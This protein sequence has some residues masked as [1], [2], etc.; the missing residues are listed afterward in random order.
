MVAP[1]RSPRFPTTGR[2]RYQLFQPTRTRWASSSSR[3]SPASSASGT[4]PRVAR[5]WVYLADLDGS[6]LPDFVETA[7]RGAG[8]RWSYRLNTGAAGASR[9]ADEGAGPTIRRNGIGNFAVDTDGDGR[10]ELIAERRYRSG[11]GELG[12]E[13]GRWR[14][15]PAGEPG[16]RRRR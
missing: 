2:Y 4:P 15:D 10:T 6:G 7:V 5:R 3:R 11:L 1:T 16:G 13:R 8:E 14:G 9:F 12:P